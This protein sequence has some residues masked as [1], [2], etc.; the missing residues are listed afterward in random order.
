MMAILREGI[1]SVGVYLMSPRLSMAA[2][3]NTALM[4]V[5]FFGSPMPR[6]ITGSPRSRSRRASSFSRR[7]AESGIE[8]ASWLILMGNSWQIRVW[9][10][11][12]FDRCSAPAAQPQAKSSYYRLGRPLDQCASSGRRRMEI[13]PFGLPTG[14]LEAGLFSLRPWHFRAFLGGLPPAETDDHQGG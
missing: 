6:W 13:L 1:P 4:G 12:P 8:R 9:N 14:R 7:V 3:L 2:E 11:P 10:S 5:L